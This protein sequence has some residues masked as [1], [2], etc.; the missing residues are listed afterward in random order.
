MYLSPIPFCSLPSRG[1]RYLKQG[2][3]HSHARY[4]SF[5]TYLYIHKL[6]WISHRAVR[7]RETTLCIRHKGDLILRIGYR[8]TGRA[9]EANRMRKLWPVLSIRPSKSILWAQF[10]WAQ[11]AELYRLPHWILFTSDFQ[12]VLAGG[13]CW[14]VVGQKR[15][16]TS[17]YLLTWIFPCRG[18]TTAARIATDVT[19]M[20]LK[21]TSC[22]CCCHQGWKHC[23]EWKG[24][25]RL[26]SVF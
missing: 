4:C 17:V 15:K 7:K 9:E 13:M 8:S 5:A 25:Q 18:A 3:Y 26:P 10:L 16:M 6:C 11:K 2:V 19:E 24:K 23:Q 12:L 14:Q 21:V 1:N 20:L 22:Y